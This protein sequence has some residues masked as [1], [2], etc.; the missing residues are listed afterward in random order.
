MSL[1]NMLTRWWGRLRRIFARERPYYTR[2]RY[3]DSLADGA[4]LTPREIAIV[5]G[6]D[7]LKWAVLVCPCGCE[8]Q[9]HVNLMRTHHPH[10]R[11]RVEDD[12]TLSFEPSLWRGAG[13]CGSHFILRR[14]YVL[15]CGQ[16]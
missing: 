3:V 4:D 16:G 11:L 6:G 2:S 7:S 1:R 10:W 12:G 5:R 9:I 14:G 8:E 15:W 13:T